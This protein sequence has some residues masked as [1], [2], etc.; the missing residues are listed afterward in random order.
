MATTRGPDPLKL[1]LQLA[2]GYG[3]YSVALDG[4]IGTGAQRVAQD[5][6]NA[7]T[8]LQR[9]AVGGVNAA[10]GTQNQ[11]QGLPVRATNQASQQTTQHTLQTIQ[12]YSSYNPI[13]LGQLDS[14]SHGMA[15]DQDSGVVYDITPPNTGAGVATTINDAFA[16]ARA[17][18]QAHGR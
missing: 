3:L 2:I 10:A 14:A 8:G 13:D 18:N 17:Y 15:W 1:A 6:R 9:G 16:R 12:R 11:T 4:Y 5:I 7:I